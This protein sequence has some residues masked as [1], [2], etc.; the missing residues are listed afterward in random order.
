MA[1][2]GKLS[3]ASIAGLALVVALHVAALYGLMKHRLIPLPDQAETLFVDFIAPPPPPKLDPQKMPAPPKPVKLEKPRPPDPHPHRVVEAPAAPSD[4][5]MPLPPPQPPAPTIEAPSLP[6]PLPA[7][8]LTLSGE[9][10]VGC[11]SRM[12]PVYPAFSQ[13]MGEEGKVV[14]RVE[15]DTEGRVDA[16]R[17][18]TSSGYKRLDEAALTAV[19]TWRCNPPLRDGQ[20]VR[21][22]ALQP[23][24]FNLE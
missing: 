15:L 1:R 2:L 3:K 7:G 13:R 10:A 4:Y 6:P 18:V 20:P 5:A 9:L 14:L 17:I 16:V 22:I 21:A 12:P 19:R 23:F 24:Q 11:P 8:P